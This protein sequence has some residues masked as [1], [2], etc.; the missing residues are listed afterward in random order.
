M[1][2]KNTIKEND[3]K[4]KNMSREEFAEELSPLSMMAQG[5]YKVDNEEKDKLNL[6]K[7]NTNSRKR[8]MNN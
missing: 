1:K 7:R 2:V 5:L 8:K 3:I 6:Q 4:N